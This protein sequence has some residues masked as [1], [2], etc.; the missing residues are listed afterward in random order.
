MGKYNS[1]LE[2]VVP[3]MISALRL[4]EHQAAMVLMVSIKYV[5]Q[6][7]TVLPPMPRGIHQSTMSAILSKVRKT[8]KG[9]SLLELNVKIS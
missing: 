6:M 7:T 4:C 2:G 9:S 1:C 8:C 5:G 3:L